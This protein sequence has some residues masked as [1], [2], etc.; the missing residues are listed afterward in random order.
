MFVKFDCEKSPHSLVIRG[1]KNV[2]IIIQFHKF[3]TKMYRILIIQ[4]IKYV[5]IKIFKN[6]LYFK[7][8]EQFKNNFIYFSKLKIV[9]LFS[10]ICQTKNI[11]IY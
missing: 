4:H 11:K 8:N 2:S 10:H 5:F 6:P 3:I 1:I 9:Y 7:E